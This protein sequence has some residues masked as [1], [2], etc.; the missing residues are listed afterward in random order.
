MSNRFALIQGDED[1]NPIRYLDDTELSDIN[2]L[3]QD[4]G[5]T[6]WVDKHD[7]PNYWDEGEAML[8][9][10]TCINPVPKKVVSEWEVPNE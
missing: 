6:E 7:D 1:G 9:R 8:V 5:V 2:Q 10:I 3:M 4:Y